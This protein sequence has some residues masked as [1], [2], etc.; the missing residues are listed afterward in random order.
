MKLFTVEHSNVKTHFDTLWEASL[1]A[2]E[3]KSGKIIQ[4]KVI[5][6]FGPKSV[7]IDRRKE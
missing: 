5:Y 6:D 1:Y 2:K 4:H 3:L 7:K